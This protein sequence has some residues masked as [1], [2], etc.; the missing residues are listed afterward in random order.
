MVVKDSTHYKQPNI[1]NKYGVLVWW[2]RGE[3]AMH[4]PTVHINNGTY[5]PP[6]EVKPT[7]S[8]RNEIWRKL[9]MNKIRNLQNT[10]NMSHRRHKKIYHKKRFYTNYI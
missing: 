1:V 6:R 10:K 3:I 9:F 5:V 4:S 7:L 2:I 8:M